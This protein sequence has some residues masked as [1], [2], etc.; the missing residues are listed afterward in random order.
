MSSGTP[1]GYNTSKT[2]QVT[3]GSNRNTGAATPADRAAM[4][5]IQADTKALKEKAARDR[6]LR[7]KN[8]PAI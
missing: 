7:E 2:N 5:K 1:A 3:I 8:K 6:A 4:D